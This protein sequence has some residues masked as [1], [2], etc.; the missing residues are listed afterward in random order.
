MPLEQEVMSLLIGGFSI[1][2][3]IAILVTIFLWIRN[4]QNQSGYIWTL[5]HLLFVSI[6][7][8][9]ALKGIA[10][11]YTH[12][13]AS[14]E[15]SLQIGISGVVWALSMLC[16]SLALVSFSRKRTHSAT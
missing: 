5:L 16:L 3:G 10:F 15:I 13:M 11:D 9:F 12:P 6:A 7:V 8:Y 14:E 2:M 4:K 1:V